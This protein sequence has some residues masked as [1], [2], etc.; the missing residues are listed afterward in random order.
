M[1]TTHETSHLLTHKERTKI[2]NCVKKLVPERYINISNPNQD[3][4]PWL[5]LVDERMPHLMNDDVPAFE[6]GVS[7]LLKSLGS[8]HTAFF[9][10]RRDSIPPPYSINATLRPVDT[11]HGKRR[12]DRVRWRNTVAS[13]VKKSRM[14]AA[15]GLEEFAY[16]GLKSGYIIVHEMRHAFVNQGKPRTV[17]LIWVTYVDVPLGN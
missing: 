12:I 11:T 14:A 9:H 15:Q 10:E 7:E 16:A 8:S 13:L 5:A 1:P 17:I 3:Y 2:I 6:A 4:G